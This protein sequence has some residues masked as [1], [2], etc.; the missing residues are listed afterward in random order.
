MIPDGNMYLCKAL[1]SVGCYITKNYHL[2][3]L[4]YHL[5]VDGDKLKMCTTNPNATIKRKDL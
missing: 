4:K 5:R 2:I 3:S 1:K